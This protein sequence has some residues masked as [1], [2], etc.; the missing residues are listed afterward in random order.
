M[1]KSIVSPKT[2]LTYS[3]GCRT[4]QAEMESI[5]LQLTAYGLRQFNPF[6]LPLSYSPDL[7]LLNT[8]V[9]TEKAERETRKEIRR[10]QRLHPKSFLVVLGCAVTAKQKFT[11]T[12]P[13]ADVNGFTAPGVRKD[14]IMEVV[15]IAWEV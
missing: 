14:V 13:D 15:P 10:L 11:I 8:C 9:V 12:C 7:I 4:N 1:A 2:Y 6:T 3:L 5:S